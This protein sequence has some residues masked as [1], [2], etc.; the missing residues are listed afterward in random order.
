[1]QKSSHWNV[2]KCLMAQIAYTTGQ[3]K[4][5]TADHGLRIGYKTRTGYKRRTM[6]YVYKNSF[7]KVKLRETQS[8]LA[9]T[10]LVPAL[11][12]LLLFTWSILPTDKKGYNYY[13]V[14]KATEIKL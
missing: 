6:D 14:L 9:K 1:M 4:T 13:A 10:V 11:T 2:L 3:Y 8:G 12:F 7:R 5:R